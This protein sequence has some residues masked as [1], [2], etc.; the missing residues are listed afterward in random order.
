MSMPPDHQGAADGSVR[1][2]FGWV[3]RLTELIAATPLP[4][5]IEVAIASL[6]R[7]GVPVPRLQAVLGDQRQEWMQRDH[8][9][10]LN[11][12]AQFMDFALAIHTYTLENPK[13]R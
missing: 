9:T 7:A 2:D 10:R 12:P 13:V 11:L 8:L 5:S 3:R 1:P 6:A 4:A